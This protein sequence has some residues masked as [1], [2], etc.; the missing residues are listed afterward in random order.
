MLHFP[1]PMQRPVVRAPT[2]GARSACAAAAPTTS[3][4]KTCSYPRRAVIA[5]PTR[6]KW[7]PLYSA[8]LTI[9]LPLVHVGVPRRGRSR[10]RCWR[11]ARSQR[12]AGRSRRVVPA[13]RAGQ[14]AR[15]R[16]DGGQSCTSTCA[17][18]TPSRPICATANA[19]AI[20]KTIAAQALLATVE[21]ALETG[22]RRRALPRHGPGAHA[23]RD[24][25]RPV[26]PAPGQTSAALQR[27]RARSAW[28][29]W[30]CPTPRRIW[31][32]PARVA[33]GR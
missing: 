29:P 4:S 12:K 14:R 16:A 13:R 32:A 31:A 30:V 17:T 6:G 19:A 22:R 3:S 28:T 1:V 5:A 25:R 9:A 24:P 18:T 26:P 20:R 15:H 8:V 27:P 7:H 21:K 10:A 2:T 23:A 11:S 33:C